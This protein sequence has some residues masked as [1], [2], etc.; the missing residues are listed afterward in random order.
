MQS[1]GRFVLMVLTSVTPIGWLLASTNDTKAQ[2]HRMQ[3]IKIVNKS[4]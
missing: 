2:N 4:L 3:I 1:D